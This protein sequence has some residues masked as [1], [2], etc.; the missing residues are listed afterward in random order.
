MNTFSLLLWTSLNAL[1]ADT[2]YVDD[3]P[4]ALEP[5]ALTADSGASMP[6]SQRDPLSDRV[7]HWERGGERRTLL[8]PLRLDARVA[9]RDQIA[10]GPLF[11]LGS[12]LVRTKAM[13]LDLNISYAIPRTILLPGPFRTFSQVS[14]DADLMFGGGRFLKV[15]PTGG[16]SY[17][18]YIQQWQAIEEGFV[19]QVGVRASSALIQARKWSLVMTARAT[20]DL[21]VTQLVMETAQVHS[22][23]PYEGQIGLRFNFGHGRDPVVQP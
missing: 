7:S 17:R 20:M 6:L 19:P 18:V 9:L 4:F 16:V 23:S 10:P 11:E 5:V 15:G 22:L 13:A 1:G 12:Q 8:P 21:M 2:P 14:L 3:E